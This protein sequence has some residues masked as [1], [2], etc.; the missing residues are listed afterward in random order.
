MKPAGGVSLAL[1][2][3][4]QVINVVVLIGFVVLAGIV[5][6]NAIVLVEQV[7]LL[8]RAGESADVALVTAARLRLRPILMTTL[9]T[10]IGM[11]PG[12]R[13]PRSTRTVCR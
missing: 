3:T 12:R 1:F 5:V 10:V 8:R 7:E 4:Q 2:L 11:L 13:T 9:T 6:N